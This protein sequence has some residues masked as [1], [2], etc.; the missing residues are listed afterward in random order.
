MLTVR[1]SYSL[2]FCKRLGFDHE[3]ASRFVLGH[4]DFRLR[5]WMIEMSLNFILV[6]LIFFFRVILLN[7]SFL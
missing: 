7:A 5:N 4:F 6:F 2:S 3:L 1:G